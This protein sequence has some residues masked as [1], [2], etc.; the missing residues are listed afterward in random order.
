MA[1]SVLLAVGVGYLA[2]YCCALI[3]VG[4]LHTIFGGLL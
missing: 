2:L 3:G 4:I 1:F